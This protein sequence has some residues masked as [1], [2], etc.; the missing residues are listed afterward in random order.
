MGANLQS[1]QPPALS[2]SLHG[3][4]H[5]IEGPKCVMDDCD[6][7]LIVGSFRLF[8]SGVSGG[9]Q[10]SQRQG[11]EELFLL[12]LVSFSLYNIYIYIYIYIL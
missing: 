1:H 8:P 6:H 3:V 10:A 4:L 2:R 12:F 7:A 5:R 9:G 11:T